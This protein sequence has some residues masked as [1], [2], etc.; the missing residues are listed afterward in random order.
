[1]IGFYEGQMPMPTSYNGF[2]V[3]LGLAISILGAYSTLT[4]MESLVQSALTMKAQQKGSIFWSVLAAALTISVNTVFLMHFISASSLSH[5]SLPGKSH[6]C[7][8]CTDAL[9]VDM[10]ALALSGV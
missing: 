2:F 6:A 4:F 9:C 10:L 1:M 3:A 8:R 5:G 7:N